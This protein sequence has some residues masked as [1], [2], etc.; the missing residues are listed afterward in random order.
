MS[1]FRALI[2]EGS[3]DHYVTHFKA[4]TADALP[5]GVVLVEV[6]YSPLNYKDALAVTGRGRIIRR[7]PMACGID[8]SGRVIATHSRRHSQSAMKC[9]SPAKD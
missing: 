1:T 2:A 3:P 5:P 4:L 7:F 8:L 6:G 9:S